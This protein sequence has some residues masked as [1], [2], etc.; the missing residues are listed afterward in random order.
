MNGRRPKRI[1]IGESAVVPRLWSGIDELAGDPVFQAWVDAE[2]PEAAEFAPTARR[3][4]LKL[5]GASFALA[6]LAGCEKS[7]FVAALP[8]VDQPENESVGVPR[9]YAT[10]VTLDGYAQ[11]VIA[12]T[13]SGRPTKLD[14]NPDHPVT[15][16]CSDVFMQAAVLGLYDPDRAQGPTRRGEPVTWSDVVAAIGT[17]RSNWGAVQGGGLRL[18]IGPTSSP[19]L[20]HQLDALAKQFPKLRIH[21]H[22]A[23]SETARRELTS[24]AYGQ[25]LDLHYVLDACDLVVSFDDD[26]LGPG[27]NQVR[28]AR[29]WAS[30]RR[31][32]AERP[33]IL[34]HMAESVPSATGAV[35]SRRLIADASRMAALAEALANRLGVGG[36]STG[37]L[38]PAEQ[39][40]I[41]NAAKACEAAGERTLVTSGPSGDVGTAIWVARINDTLKTAGHSVKFS[42]PITGPANAASIQDLVA[43]MRTGKVQ[44]L[45]ILDCNPA[46]TAPGAL[47]FADALR[48]VQSTLHLGLQRDETGELC[49]WQLPLT[50]ALESWSD[51]RAVDGTASIIQPTIAPFYD[52]RSIHQIM[53][54]LLGEI[55]PAADTAVR[56]TWQGSFGADFDTRWKQALHDGFVEGAAPEVGAMPSSAAMPPAKAAGKGLDIVFRP[57]P[58]IWDGR[59]S[60]VGWLQ[61]LPKPLTTL[62]W[63][64]VVAVSPSLAK[65]LEIENGDHV[66][67]VIGNRNAVGPAWIMP[68]QAEN[69]VALF[70]GYGRRRAGRVGDGLG[71]DAYNVRPVDQPWL[72]KGSLRKTGGAETLAVTQLHHRMEGFDFVREVSAEHPTLPKH[73]APPSLYPPWPSSK[74]AWGMVIDLDSCIG[75]NACVAACTAE[76]NVP[77]VGKEQVTVGREMHWIRIAR[78]YSGEVESPRSFFQPVPCMQCEQAPCEMGCPVHATTHSPEGVNQMVYNRCI[79]TRT[80]SS[81]CPYKVRRFNFYDYRT[82]PES[83]EHAAQNPDV[84]VRSRGVM[85]KC[86]YCTQRIEAAH[87]AADK[88]NRSL[89]DGD[90]VTACQAACPTKAIVF[91]DIND[92][93]SEVS[94]LRRDGR[95]YVLLE[96]LGTRPRTTYLARWRDGGGGEG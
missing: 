10:A 94:R 70:L 80:C 19:T 1:Q 8:Y 92:P 3:Q 84:T 31:R 15:K 51:A 96:E 65:R 86:T 54:M 35:A 25:P 81:F 43:D 91:G 2:Y 23:A 74:N 29:G 18:L 36:A 28:N 68:G 32:L 7:P 44:T 40:W 88:E 21:L 53:A 60:N 16:G 26:F 62:T 20:L 66:E 49:A 33:G 77:V 55:N 50:H 22:D 17:L 45:V 47:G 87:A 52:V 38:T 64:N 14:G 90:V 76:N 48:Q 61:E 85:E 13:W 82:P 79:G 27:P 56:G 6:G 46:Y 73:D 89:R 59:F 11:P 93:N 83:P 39:G 34:L 37:E 67:A 5:M 57:D 71:Y 4:F 78:Y 41:E 12:T 58:T 95:H 63:S 75:C 69:T 30:S 72:T 42:Q 24:V 9:T